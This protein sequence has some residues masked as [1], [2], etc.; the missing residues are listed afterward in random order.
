MRYWSPKSTSGEC[1]IKS[2]LIS[3]LSTVYINFIEKKSIPLRQSVTRALKRKSFQKRNPVIVVT[4]CSNEA[5]QG[6]WTTSD[7]ASKCGDNL[8]PKYRQPPEVDM[9][10][11]TIHFSFRQSDNCT[12]FFDGDMTVVTWQGQRDSFGALL[13]AFMVDQLH[14]Y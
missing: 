8:L 3:H 9:K 2:H 13:F 10:G 5:F 6:V 12:F 4:L 1:S 14:K 11:A 7:I